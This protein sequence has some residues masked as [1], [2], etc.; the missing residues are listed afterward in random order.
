M[1][2]RI[3]T[4]TSLAQ[5]IAYVERLLK[6]DKQVFWFRGHRK[7]TFVLKPT[8]FR[9]KNSR[10]EEIVKIE[11][12]LYREFYNRSPSFDVIQR[13]DQ[14]DLL[15][16]MQHYRVPTRLLD[17]TASPLSALFFALFQADEK[18]DATV[19]AVNP[20]EWN[21]GMLADIGNDGEIYAT[22]DQLIEQ[23]HPMSDVK[24][25]R[26]EPLAIEGIINNPRINA[27]KGK[28]IIFGQQRYDLEHF[29][30]E[31]PRWKRHTPLIKILIEKQSIKSIFHSV[32]NFGVTHS[33]IYPDLEGLALE[34][35]A[36]YGFENV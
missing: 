4:V 13:K 34:L 19:W 2:A 22:G 14:W 32:I 9:H 21:R 25:K 7:S 5:Y 16:L 15:F 30:K 28:F 20:A 11:R 23:Y 12:K 18:Q 17:W 27:Q 33:T 6:D 36:K 3:K 1:S 10:Y 31:C 24:T 29:A 8:L 26:A 35:K